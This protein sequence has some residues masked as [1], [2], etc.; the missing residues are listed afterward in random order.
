[1]IAPPITQQLHHL[2]VVNDIYA[3]TPDRRFYAIRP[4]RFHMWQLVSR[5]HEFKPTS[6][7]TVVECDARLT[8]WLANP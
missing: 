6:R 5:D 8:V 2:T 3:E 1:M 7:P 4:D